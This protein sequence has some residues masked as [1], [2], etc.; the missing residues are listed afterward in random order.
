MRPG[1]DDHGRDDLLCAEVAELTLDLRNFSYALS[2]VF[3]DARVPD[4]PEMAAAILALKARS[5]GLADRLDR[6]ARETGP[7][8]AASRLQ[9]AQS[10]AIRPS[11]RR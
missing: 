6:A 8:A 4:R 3:A 11:P 7:L 5:E 10:G 9:S 1:P 2:D